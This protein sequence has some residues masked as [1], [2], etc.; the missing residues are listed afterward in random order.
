MARQKQ[1]MLK[2]LIGYAVDQGLV[3]NEGFRRWHEATS[4]Q[5]R[6]R[7]MMEAIQ[8]MLDHELTTLNVDAAIPLEVTPEDQRWDLV[9]NLRES[10]PYTRNALAHGS[11]TLTWQV[12]GTLE[13]VA[14]ILGQLYPAAATP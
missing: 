13:V 12:L 10:I 4:H 8:Q 7:R 5:A 3:R 11:T 1:P 6:E 14:E 2:G 9:N